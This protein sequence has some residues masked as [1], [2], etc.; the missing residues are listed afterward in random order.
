MFWR[1]LFY[2]FRKPPRKG[3]GAM[4]AVLFDIV[5]VIELC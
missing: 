1:G 5:V 3:V 4:I 2:T